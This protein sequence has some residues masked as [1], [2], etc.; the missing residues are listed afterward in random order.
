MK[1]EELVEK[2]DARQKTY[3]SRQAQL[4]QVNHDYTMLMHDLVNRHFLEK[5]IDRD[6]KKSVRVIS[7][8][9]RGREIDGAQAE[10]AVVGTLM[11]MVREAH[12]ANKA[13]RDMA[14]KDRED[15]SEE[16]LSSS[17]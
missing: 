6:L 13:G 10:V 7:E 5:F 4:A 3:E 14:L 2:R 12:K 16:S 9:R 15:S 17:P 11:A 8:S 1:Y